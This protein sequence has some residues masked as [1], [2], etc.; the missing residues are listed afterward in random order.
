[1]NI[2]DNFKSSIVYFSSKN[3]NNSI[4]KKLNI[5]INLF[6]TNQRPAIERILSGSK[7]FIKEYLVISATSFD[8]GIATIAIKLIKQ[9]TPIKNNLGWKKILGSLKNRN[10]NA[11]KI[12]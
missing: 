12:A 5:S 4:F 8:W 9:S 11:G 10:N 3:F 2:Y 6:S 1:M 7:I